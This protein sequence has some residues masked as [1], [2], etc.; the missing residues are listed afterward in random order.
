MIPYL[1]LLVWIHNIRICWSGPGVPIRTDT[2][3]LY[4]KCCTYD[5]DHDG[6]VD[7]HDLSL[8]LEAAK[9]WVCIE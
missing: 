8:M 4:Q 7:L 9:G 3:T 1:V 2:Q 5:L 6:D